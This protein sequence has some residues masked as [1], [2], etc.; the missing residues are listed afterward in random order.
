MEEFF[1]KLNGKQSLVSLPG[2]KKL[3][4]NKTFSPI[5]LV[6]NEEINNWRPANDIEGI[7]ELF[8]PNNNDGSQFKRKIYTIASGKGGV[9]KSSL[10]ASIGV[11]LA[12]MGHNVILVDADFSGPNLHTILGISEPK[13]TLFDFYT[14]QRESLND[15]LLETPVKNL[16]MISGACGTLGLANQKYFQKQKF[17][18]HLRKLSADYIILDLGSGANYN[19]LDLFLLADEKILIVTPEPTSILEAFNF[20]KVSFYRGLLRAL[21]NRAQALDILYRM[22]VNRPDHIKINATGLLHNISRVD[23]E[24]G[25]IFKSILIS[26]RPKIILNMLNKQEDLKE[27]MAIQTAAKDLLSLNVDYLGYIPNDP[28]VG[29]SVKNSQPFLLHNPKSKASQYLVS[30]ISDKLKDTHGKNE[31]MVK[32]M[33]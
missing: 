5:D 26:Y 22:E 1:I 21:K 32:N 30:L 6:W 33:G 20:I 13:Y 10:T 28:D 2:L 16:H 23:S 25:S 7:N 15:I 24:A 8:K 19:V 11:G 14:L 17:I 9:G 18:R 31:L 12:Q 4:D 29:N 27:V 3:V